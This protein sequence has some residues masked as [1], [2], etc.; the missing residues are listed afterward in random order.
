LGIAL[1]T[2][3]CGGDS[4]G[5]TATTAAEPATTEAPGTTSTGPSETSAPPA[6]GATTPDAP[7]TTAEPEA[8]PEADQLIATFVS[9][10]DPGYFDAL[11]YSSL[12]AEY[13]LTPG[14]V[15]SVVEYDHATGRGHEVSSGP[16][17]DDEVWLVDRIF[18]TEF[19]GEAV[20]RVAPTSPFNMLRSDGLFPNV[21][22][23]VFADAEPVGTVEL[24]GQ[25]LTEYV[26]EGD[27]A[28]AYLADRFAD[29]TTEV[30]YRSAR[31]R[32]LVN[33]A[34]ALVRYETATSSQ[35]DLFGP[36]FVDGTLSF[37]VSALSRPLPEPTL[38]RAAD[39]D[40]QLAKAYLGLASGQYRFLAEEAGNADI[41]LEEV[42]AAWP[43][44]RVSSVY[45]IGVSAPG[46]ANTTTAGYDDR[47][48][49]IESDSG[50]WFCVG[51]RAPL[52]AN[53]GD[54]GRSEGSGDSAAD[55]LA[56][57]ASQIAG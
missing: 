46:D 57:C 11:G 16:R 23:M 51:Y 29:S 13:E 42:R 18:V 20:P 7:V 3:A 54:R 1:S 53:F 8:S 35:N 21:D 27:E 10:S 26:V 28:L 48:V 15:R 39:Y 14:N 19:L 22:V 56:D 17:G 25:S 12:Q 43:D 2:S 52:E 32:A 38:P 44:A 36:D 49:V 47:I 34:G 40:D 31:F 41:S 9:P 6:T 33:A 24:D 37:G 5:S 45:G 4:D 55:A 50:T 30:Q